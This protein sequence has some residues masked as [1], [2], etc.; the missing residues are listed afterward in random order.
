MEVVDS[1]LF[2]RLC[3]SKFIN[4]AQPEPTG[5]KLMN[6]N[7]KPLNTVRSECCNS[8]LKSKMP[9]SHDQSNHTNQCDLL[10]VLFR[11]V[12]SNTVHLFTNEILPRP[13]NL[14]RQNCFR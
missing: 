13:E 1:I 14:T 6:V 5:N 2:T 7:K 3:L 10:P 9:I 4:N 12:C 11:Q 8:T